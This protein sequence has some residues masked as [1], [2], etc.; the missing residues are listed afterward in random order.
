MLFAVGG[1]LV[2]CQGSV[3]IEEPGGVA[4]VGG[5]ESLSSAVAPVRLAPICCAAEVGRAA[6][7]GRGWVSS[8][9][10]IR[11]LVASRG[12]L[13]MK[14]ER[15]S[16]TQHQSDRLTAKVAS[17]A[18]QPAA[19]LGIHNRSARL[20]HPDGGWSKRRKR[21]RGPVRRAVP[22][23]NLAGVGA[24]VEILALDVVLGAAVAVGTTAAVEIPWQVGTGRHAGAWTGDAAYGVAAD[25]DVGDCGDVGGCAG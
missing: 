24:A 12:I 5:L 16:T 4:F 14:E 2:S 17:A 22:E 9:R 19:T 20:A 15:G 25:V 6:C 13:S 3:S 7:E 10:F 1:L 23:P 21:R 8:L 11:M 18:T